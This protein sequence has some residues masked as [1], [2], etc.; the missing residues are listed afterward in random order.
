MKPAISTLIVGLVLGA[1][2]G[3][4]EPLGVEP[5]DD[6]ATAAPFEPQF[7]HGGRTF[8]PG[9]QQP[10]VDLKRGFTYAIYPEGKGQN[11]VQTFSP[12]RA[13]RLGYIELPV[14]CA[15]GVALQV[16][17]REGIGGP[18]LSE[19]GYG[20]LPAV[21]DGSF[22]TLQ[23]FDPAVSHGLKLKKKITYAIELSAIPTGTETTCGLAPGPAANSYGDGDG[24][25][26]DV[27]TNG[28]GWIPLGGGEDLPFRTL[29][30]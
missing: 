8:V 2:A 17:I 5:A 27:P 25:Y 15:A 1:T 11:L 29:V 14:G 3:C 18:I 30:L 6:L 7:A 23:V 13:Q 9:E 22:Q 16:R 12:S 24:Y 20:G 4:S 10:I 28:P 26:E 21:V 19:M